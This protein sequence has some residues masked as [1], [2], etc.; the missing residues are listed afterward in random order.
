MLKNMLLPVTINPGA[1]LGR[2]TGQIL[3]AEASVARTKEVFPLMPVESDDGR[4]PR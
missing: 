2:G 1:G 4:W 3:A